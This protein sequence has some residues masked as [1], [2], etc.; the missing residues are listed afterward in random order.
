MIGGFSDN[1]GKKD[2]GIS[3][4]FIILQQ[5]EEIKCDTTYMEI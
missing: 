2:L 5:L 3:V 4:F 1:F